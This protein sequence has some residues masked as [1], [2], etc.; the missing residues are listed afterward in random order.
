M[1]PLAKK[2]LSL[3]L[4]GGGEFEHFEVKVADASFHFFNSPLALGK[5]LGLGNEGS[6]GTALDVVLDKIDG[7]GDFEFAALEVPALGIA[8][9]IVFLRIDQAC[10]VI[11]GERHRGSGLL[12]FVQSPSRESADVSP[13]RDSES[14]LRGQALQHLQRADPTDVS[15]WSFS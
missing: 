10:G 3:F 8:V 9:A 12:I 11:V 4:L 1:K 6:L 15:P 14:P 5:P 7:G 13:R 2:P